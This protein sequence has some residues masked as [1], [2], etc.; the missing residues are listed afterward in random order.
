MSSL[1]DTLYD[2]FTDDPAEAL[3]RAP[4]LEAVNWNTVESR[5]IPLLASPQGG[6][7]ERSRKYREA[8]LIARPGW[9][10]DGCKRKTTPAA[11]ASVAARHFS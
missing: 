10:S 11:S 6:V 9:F 3:Q 7:A 5:V 1:F 2:R 4:A 8:P